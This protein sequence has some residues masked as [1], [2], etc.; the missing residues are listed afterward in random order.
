[1]SKL[2]DLTGQR[3]GRLTVIKKANSISGQ[4]Y[5][6]CKCD[7]GNE[8]TVISYCLRKGDTKSCGCL[9]N[10]L[11]NSGCNSKHRKS[12]TKLYGVW[13]TMKGRCYNPNNSKYKRY[14]GR[15]IIVCQEWRE[16]Q[17]FYEWAMSHGYT[18]ELTIDR[19][20][21]DGNYE[22]ANCRWATLKE[23][24]NNKCNTIIITFNSETKTLSEW[25]KKLNIS[26]LCLWKRI[27]LRNWSVEK[28]LTTPLKK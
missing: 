2:I 21:N 23:Q 19:I 20:N 22:P 27:Y 18:E 10:E 6:L 12:S 11:I 25:A 28:A 4:T 16:F 3:F 14:G 13:S 26:R 24:A 5:W 1:M 7:C 15:G 8:T 9:H 17:P